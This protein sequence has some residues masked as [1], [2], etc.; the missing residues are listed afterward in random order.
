[1]KA[2]GP[3]KIPLFLYTINPRFMRS[4]HGETV[5]YPNTPIYTTQQC[6][7]LGYEGRTEPPGQTNPPR[8]ETPSSSV[9][10]LNPLGRNPPL[11]DRR[12]R[13]TYMCRQ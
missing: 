1:M 11:S 8:S 9:V 12:R 6:W 13:F 2:Q 5:K 7:F 4:L 10:G 3:E